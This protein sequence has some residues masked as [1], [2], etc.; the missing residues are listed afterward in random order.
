MLRIL[1]VNT[2]IIK[3][4]KEAIELPRRPSLQRDHRKIQQKS[5]KDQKIT[6]VTT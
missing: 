6:L 3:Q 4:I 1:A 2:N 5:L